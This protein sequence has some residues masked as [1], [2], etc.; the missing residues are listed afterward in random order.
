MRQVRKWLKVTN[1]LKSLRI[2]YGLQLSFH[3]TDLRLF[4]KR[5]YLFDVEIVAV[6]IVVAAVVIVVAVVIAVA[7][8]AKVVETAMFLKHK[9]NDEGEMKLVTIQGERNRLK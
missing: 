8:F 9:M 6:V 3:S 2:N 7:V 4:K 5:L 1:P